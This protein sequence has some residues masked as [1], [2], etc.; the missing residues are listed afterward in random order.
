MD[1]HN[2]KQWLLV[3]QPHPVS[4]VSTEPEGG[5][6]DPGVAEDPFTDMV[7]TL[8][9]SRDSED[10]FTDF[11]SGTASE[12][13]QPGHPGGSEQGESSLTRGSDLENAWVTIEAT[14]VNGSPVSAG[15]VKF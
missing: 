10:S 1:L 9:R 7:N 3:C 8:C 4:A 13:A 2:V 14:D 5:L 12:I 6:G 11:E 15:G